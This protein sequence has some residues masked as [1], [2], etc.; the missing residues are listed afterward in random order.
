MNQIDLLFII[1]VTSSMG[2]FIESAKKKMKMM[3][4]QL[5][6]KYEIDL[7]VSLSLFRDHPSQDKSFVTVV[8]DLMEINDIQQKIDQI[9]VSGGGDIP[10]AVIDGIID[11]ITGVQWR[12]KSRR[13][14]FLIGDAPPH[15]MD[16][17]PCCL[18]GKTWGDAVFVA[19]N[20]KV[21]I[22]SIVLS[23][24][25][26]A[27]DSFKTISNFTGG[28]L[29]EGDDAMNII[30]NTLKETFD[31]VNLDSKVLEM[32]SKN[33]TLEQICDMLEINREK[34]SESKTRITYFS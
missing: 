30:L 31:G 28:M 24:D 15:G 5:S 22:Y 12:E 4:E 1:D 32:M 8:F 9:S 34:I 19:N 26:I 23:E 13:I 21:V 20:N 17:K 29:I 6:S 27:K 25:V 18:C 2:G 14:A 3:L 10:E 11:G 16:G 33:Y 7:R